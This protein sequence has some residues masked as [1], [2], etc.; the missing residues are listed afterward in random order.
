[1]MTTKANISPDKEGHSANTV[2][3]FYV[4]G[5]GKRGGLVFRKCSIAI[6]ISVAVFFA[7][8][9]A[10]WAAEIQLA[11]IILG[12]SSLSVI[13]KYGDPDDVRVGGR[14]QIAIDQSAANPFGMEAPPPGIGMETPPPGIGMETPPPGFGADQ[15]A[16][17]PGMSSPFGLGF[18]V[19][20]AT[21]MSGREITWIYRFEKNKELDFLLDPQGRVLQIAAYGVEWKG[22]K[23]SKGIGLGKTYKEVILTY[24]FP[25]SHEQ[26]P[27]GG[28]V[29]KYAN[30]DRVAFTL[31]GN[32]VV[33]ITIAFM[34]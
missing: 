10:V 31:V 14:G 19:P 26:Q 29:L 5:S 28:M 30:S 6:I 34:D 32:Q 1:M 24:G 27:L 11:G 20:Q 4:N 7:A 18:G 3:A 8:T 2:E 16:M 9:T 25:E 13:K 12:R 21:Q 15:G 17:Q 22:M 33:G 23:T